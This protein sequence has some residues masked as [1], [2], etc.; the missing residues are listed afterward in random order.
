MQGFFR[1]EKEP[2]WMPNINSPDYGMMEFG[3]FGENQD[4]QKPIDVTQAPPQQ[5]MASPST[6]GQQALGGGLSIPWDKLKKGFDAAHSGNNESEPFGSPAFD[7]NN[8]TYDAKTGEFVANDQGPLDSQHW[9]Y[10]AAGNPVTDQTGPFDS[11]KYDLGLYDPN[12]KGPNFSL[13]MEGLGVLD[14]VSDMGGVGDEIAAQ[15]A[16]GI[17]SGMMDGLNKALPFIQGAKGIYGL[18]QGSG[19]QGG[20]DLA[21][22]AGSYFVP[23]FGWAKAG[24]DT[25]MGV[26]NYIKGRGRQYDHWRPYAID[27][28]KD[29]NGVNITKF[30]YKNASSDANEMGQQNAEAGSGGSF[31]GGQ[32]DYGQGRGSEYMVTDPDTGKMYWLNPNEYMG[33][34]SYNDYY[35]LNEGMVDGVEVGMGGYT[36]QRPENMMGREDYNNRLSGMFSQ[37]MN[38]N[39]IDFGGKGLT[40]IQHGQF[41]DEGDTAMRQGYSNPDFLVFT[42]DLK[43]IYQQ[44]AAMDTSQYGADYQ[45]PTLAAPVYADNGLG[46]DPTYYGI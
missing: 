11:D 32:Y 31:I 26:G 39:G 30:G 21:T 17:G 8:Y 14:N 6:Q 19:A 29:K 18:T 3:G 42:E 37:E 24:F 2:D 27:T 1:F 5:G 20:V 9:S 4:G 12:W 46:S 10:D 41:K 22:G 33:Q 15:G 40:E 36:P 44:G 7:S 28:I 35:G 13:D 45:A 38:E 16:E 34:Q 25:I 23:A 43:R